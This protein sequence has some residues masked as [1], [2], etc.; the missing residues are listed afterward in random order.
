LVVGWLF[1]GQIVTLRTSRLPLFCPSTRSTV[2]RRPLRVVV[3]S[4]EFAPIFLTFTL[5][6]ADIGP[7]AAYS[8]SS[9]VPAYTGPVSVEYLT[10]PFSNGSNVITGGRWS[11]LVLLRS[12]FHVPTRGSAA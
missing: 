1:T 12:C 11:N 8:F 6:V 10:P 3:T 7:S 9:N 5:S 4:Y 2:V